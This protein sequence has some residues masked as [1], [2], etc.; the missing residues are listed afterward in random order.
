MAKWTAQWASLECDRIAW[1]TVENSMC[2]LEVAEGG[3]SERRN[4]QGRNGRVEM[5]TRKQPPSECACHRS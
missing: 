3:K 4:P 1:Q 5:E 2:S